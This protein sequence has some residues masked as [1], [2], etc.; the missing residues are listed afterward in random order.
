MNRSERAISVLGS[1]RESTPCGVWLEPETNLAKGGEP[2]RGP[3]IAT[4]LMAPAI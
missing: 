2:V 4:R 3:R 1:D